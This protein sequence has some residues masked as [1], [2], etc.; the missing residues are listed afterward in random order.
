MSKLKLAVIF[1]GTSTEHDVSMVSATSVI[2]NLNKEKYEIYPT[3]ID[4]EGNWHNYT[5]LII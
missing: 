4:K 1:G 3:Y 5:K 2:Q